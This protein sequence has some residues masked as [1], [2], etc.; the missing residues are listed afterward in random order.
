MTVPFIADRNDDLTSLVPLPAQKVSAGSGVLAA[1]IKRLKIPGS[2]AH[3]VCFDRTAF[4]G[5]STERVTLVS[6]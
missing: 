6:E 1:L 4:F 5:N 2:S 3:G